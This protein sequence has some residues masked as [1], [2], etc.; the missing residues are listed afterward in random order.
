MPWILQ[1]VQFGIQIEP[2]FGFSFDEVKAIARDAE[3]LGADGVWISDHLF[4]NDGS[5]K[6]DCLEAW[7]LLAALTQITTRVRLRTPRAGP[8]G[9]DPGLGLA[10]AGT[11]G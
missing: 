9:P 8:A 4:L 5:A 7:T 11:R 2:Q 1:T 10:Q 6:T 3:E